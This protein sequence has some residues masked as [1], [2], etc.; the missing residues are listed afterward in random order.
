MVDDEGETDTDPDVA[1]PVEK[2]VP[3]HEVALEDDHDSVEELPCATE[4]GEADNEHV[5]G[6]LSTVHVEYAYD[7]ESVP[8]EQVRVC[9]THELPY[10]TVLAW[11]AVTLELWLTV[12][13]LNVQ[14]AGGFT[15]KTAL[16]Q[17]SDPPYPYA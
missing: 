16:C 9:E 4:V 11:Y 7:P 2:L 15:L 10:D 13:P 17:P 5:G 1:P 6:G 8:F 3:V 12:A 14:F